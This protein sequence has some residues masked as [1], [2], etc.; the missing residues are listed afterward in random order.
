MEIPSNDARRSFPVIL[1]CALVQGWALY[2]LH[3]SIKSHHWPATN[4]AWLLA[5]YSVFVFS[6]WIPRYQ[7]LFSD[8]WRNKLT[9][10]N[11][12]PLSSEGGRF[13]ADFCRGLF[14]GGC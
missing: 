1:L 13:R 12:I 4:P 9:L 7:Q 6:S 5:L 14:L 10:R 8:A 11:R 2:G 3:L